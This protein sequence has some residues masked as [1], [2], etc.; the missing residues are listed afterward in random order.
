MD[1]L[2]GSTPKGKAYTVWLMR[3]SHQSRSE[4][5]SPLYR[6]VPLRLPGENSE[7]I[8]F[9]DPEIKYP[10]VVLPYSIAWERELLEALDMK[11][12]HIVICPSS[13]A[14]HSKFLYVEVDFD[15][16]SRL[17][18]RF[19]RYP[20]F[21]LLPLRRYTGEDVDQAEVRPEITMERSFR[22]KHMPYFY[23]YVLGALWELGDVFTSGKVCVQIMHFKRIRVGLGKSCFGD[24]EKNME[25]WLATM[26]LE[27]RDEQ[28][29]RPL[30]GGL[31]EITTQASDVPEAWGTFQSVC[32][33][34]V[35]PYWKEGVV[36]TV[37]LIQGTG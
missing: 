15:T 21:A 34:N 1:R 18:T 32:L 26:G 8:L 23:A 11:R 5:R 4:S 2:I 37:L 19:G 33:T 7:G 13:D 3:T 9:T 30:T 14:A 36:K 35:P 12:E 27:I 16:T 31:S 20:H 24:V 10:M 28:T 22:E 6:M 29:G 17:V 25:S